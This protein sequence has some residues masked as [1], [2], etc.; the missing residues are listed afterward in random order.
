MLF[1]DAI[2]LLAVVPPCVIFGVYVFYKLIFW[3]AVPK[4]MRN[5][6][7]VQT[8]VWMATLAPGG[9]LGGATAYFILYFA[10]WL[11]MAP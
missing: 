9:L 1:K 11:P 5:S 3:V 8:A 7:S 10:H 6:P 2:V 4:D